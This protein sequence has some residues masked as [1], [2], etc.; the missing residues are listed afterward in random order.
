[1]VLFICFYLSYIV[2]TV[3]AIAV[4]VAVVMLC[5]QQA[6]MRG[7]QHFSIYFQCFSKIRKKKPNI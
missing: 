6:F 3:V 7:S 4:A 1:M 5:C 2:D